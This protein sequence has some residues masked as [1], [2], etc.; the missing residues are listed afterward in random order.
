MAR[1]LGASIGKR[2]RRQPA[3][4][5]RMSPWLERFTR[6]G[7][8]AKGVLY[9]LIGNTALLV[10]FG[11]AEEARGSRGVLRL[12]AA[13][14]M[15]RLLIVA[16]GIG[17]AGYSLLSFVAAMRAPEAGRGIGLVLTRAADAAAGVV[18]AALVALAVRLLADPQPSTRVASELWAVRLM[19]A[20]GGRALLGAIGLIVT[21]VSLF[22]F[23]RAA[24]MPVIARFERRHVAPA[25]L[26]SVAIVA[27]VGITARGVL[28][29]LCGWLLLRAGWMGEP[30]SVG[31][32]GV[33]LD[34][35]AAAPAGH[36]VV[37]VVGAGCVAYGIYQLAKARWRRLRLTDGRGGR[38]PDGEAP[39]R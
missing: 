17:L 39:P 10:A 5:I 35:L 32:L 38:T 24:A 30:R 1:I 7:Y 8:A 6:A 27:R 25:L 15:G 2:D 20:P 31:G 29:A 4:H 26:R 34:A 16:L 19:D 22:L 23:Y 3:R 33:A 12:V 13:L 21:G 9:L 11:I 14:P 18:Y 36:T 37:G 28:Y